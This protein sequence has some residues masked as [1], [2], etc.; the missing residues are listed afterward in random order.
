MIGAKVMGYFDM[1]KG[2]WEFFLLKSI[3]SRK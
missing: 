1:T 2:F 3:K